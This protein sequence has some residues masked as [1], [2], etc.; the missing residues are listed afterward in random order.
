MASSANDTNW[1]LLTIDPDAGRVTVLERWGYQW[2]TAPGVAAWQPAEQTDFHKKV[3]QQI[4]T[5]FNGVQLTLTGSA[6]VCQ[7]YSKLPLVFDIGWSLEQFKH[8]TV[9]ARKMPAG[10][11]PLSFISNVVPST[12]TIN[13]DTGDF[14]S[15]NVCNAAGQCRNFNALPHE[16]VHTLA[17]TAGTN[18]DEYNAGSPFLAD[19]DS[20]LNVGSQ[21]RGRHLAVILGELNK[22]ITDCTFSYP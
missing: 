11:T 9:F 3:A 16:F 1:A 12:R 17:G 7:K 22:M 4:S 13:I 15:Y 18:V 21:L 8:W 6:A 2:V 19:T 5:T 20:V 10:S 14:A